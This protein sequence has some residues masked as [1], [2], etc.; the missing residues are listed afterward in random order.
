MSLLLGPFKALW[1]LVSALVVLT[2]RL[3]AIVIG[4][5]LVVIG[6]LLTATVVGAVVGIPLIAIGLLLIARGLF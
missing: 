6:A 2:G 1:R 4:L 5:C 3:V